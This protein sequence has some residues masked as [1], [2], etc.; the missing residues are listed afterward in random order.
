MRIQFG[1]YT[2]FEYRGRN[3]RDPLR[4]QGP[5]GDSTPVA[6]QQLLIEEAAKSPAG[7][8]LLVPLAHFSERPASISHICVESDR[9]LRAGD[10]PCCNN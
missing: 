3:K 1:P 2:M 5:V 7:A 9:Q 8:K 6:K 10:P 4:M